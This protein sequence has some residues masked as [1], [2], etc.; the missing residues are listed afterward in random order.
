MWFYDLNGHHI[1]E[2]VFYGLI[3]CEGY[4]AHNQ[5]QSVTVGKGGIILYSMI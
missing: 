5:Q 4:V 1:I 2:M 3:L